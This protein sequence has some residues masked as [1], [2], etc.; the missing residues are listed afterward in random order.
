MYL[1]VKEYIDMKEIVDYL[2]I[3]VIEGFIKYMQD[4]NNQ[5]RGI[6]IYIHLSLDVSIYLTLDVFISL[7]ISLSL[8]IYLSMYLLGSILIGNLA[9]SNVLLADVKV[10][11]YLSIYVNCIIM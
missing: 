6:Y 11:I 1:Y 4:F 3:H 5:C 2:D 10:S 9:C 7:C 8:C